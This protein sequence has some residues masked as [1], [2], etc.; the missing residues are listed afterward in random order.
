MYWESV[1]TAYKNGIVGIRNPTLCVVS[2]LT[3][4]GKRAVHA[5]TETQRRRSIIREREVMLR[6]VKFSGSKL[7]T[8]KRVRFVCMSRVLGSGFH[9]YVMVEWQVH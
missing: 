7:Q 3:K 1:V 4:L 8:E 2:F 5:C 9:E 6:W